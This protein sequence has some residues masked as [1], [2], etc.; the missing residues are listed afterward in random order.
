MLVF[1]TVFHILKLDS[2]EYN[3]KT[4]DV[5]IMKSMDVDFIKSGGDC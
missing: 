3:N 2:Y 1:V 5:G 4:M